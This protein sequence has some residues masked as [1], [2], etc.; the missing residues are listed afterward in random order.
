MGR[1]EAGGAVLMLRHTLGDLLRGADTHRG[2]CWAVVKLA[3]L[4]SR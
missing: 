4:F 2:Q 3:E 1:G